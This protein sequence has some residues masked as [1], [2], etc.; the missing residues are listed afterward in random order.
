MNQKLKNNSIIKI[1]IDE[2]SIIKNQLKNNK[3]KI[4]INQNAMQVY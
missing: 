2:K 1:S 4:I 3:I